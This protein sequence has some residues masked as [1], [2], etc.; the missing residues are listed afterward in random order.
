MN[1]NKIN[2]GVFVVT[3]LFLNSIYGQSIAEL[4]NNYSGKFSWNSKIGELTF[5][6]SGE[7][8]FKE[9]G[10]KGFIWD[11]PVEVKKIIIS[12]NTTVNGGFHTKDDCMILGENRKTSVVYGTEL[13]SW[14]QKNKIK[15]A[16]IS[17]FEVHGGTL[18]IQNITSLN[19]RSFHVRGLAA[20]VHLKN[21][22][23]I[24]TRGGSGNH[25]DGIAAGDGSTV[26][27]CYFETG[28]DVIKVYNDITVTNTTINMV[29]N[30]VPIQ[31]GWGDYPNGAVGTFKNLTI[32]GNSGRGN[33]KAS[34]AIIVGRSGKYTVTVNIDG[35]IIDNPTASMV[36]LFDDKNDGVFE[37]TVKGTLKNVTIKNIKTYSTQL[38]GNDELLLFDTNGNSISN[39]F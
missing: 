7:I 30:A 12:E 27:N 18:S 28:D 6:K 32:I 31:L 2:C 15:A 13:Q 21:S 22:D 8:N 25:S 29:K 17:S 19:P 34:N 23:F 38:N 36:N 14:P 5:E 4:Q 3:L 10:T 20:V 33:P 16:T 37:K 9:K 26:D 24:D 39:N 1:Y 35:L 11:V